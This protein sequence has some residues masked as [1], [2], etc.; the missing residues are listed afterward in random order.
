MQSRWREI[1][2]VPRKKSD[3]VWARF[4]AACDRFFDRYKRRDQVEIE[5][6]IKRRESLIE[7]LTALRP[8]NR[9]TED[10]LAERVSSIWTAWKIAGPPPDPGSEIAARFEN[11]VG[12][13]LLG[14]PAAFAGTELDPA[15]SAKKRGKIVGRIEAL[16]DEI[17]GRKPQAQAIDDLA[18]RLKD[19]LASNTIGGG[20]KRE[21]AF[22]WRQ[23]SEEVARLQANWAKTAP[24]PGEEGRALNE[25][26]ERAFKSFVE[27]RPP[28]RQRAPS[29]GR[30]PL[31]RPQ[32]R[33]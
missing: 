17:Q 25:R 10:R 31:S 13:I 12:V 7:E 26:F 22:D 33:A 2:A 32:S 11:E 8:E 16:V 1:G 28:E 21:D 30:A 6:R 4:R 18:Q 19:A 15:V 14:A 23:A 29:S 24:V 9:A 20:R 27:R 3:E 5:E